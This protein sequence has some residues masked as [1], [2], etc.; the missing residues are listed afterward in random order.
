MIDARCAP[1]DRVAAIV[2]A[3]RPAPDALRRLISALASQV[4]AIFV[5]DNTP[6][7]ERGARV[8]LDAFSE[9]P[10]T[11]LLETGENLGIAAALNIGIRLAMERGFDYLL[12]SDQDSEPAPDMVVH[13]LDVAGQL[14]KQGVRLGAIGPAYLDRVT[15]STFGFQVHPEGSLFYRTLPGDQADPWVEVVTSITSGSLVPCSAITDIGLMREDYFI[16]YVDTEWC[17][18]ARHHGYRLFGT[19]RARMEHHLGDSAFP[20]WYLRWRSF[21]GY[22]PVRL[23]YRFRNFMVLFRCDYVPWHWKVRAGWY[24]L[25]NLYAYAVFAP[26]RMRNLRYIGL[27]LWDGLHGRMGVYRPR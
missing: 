3:F 18:R 20:V 25:G 22:S 19:S 5:I 24:W 9:S 8:A 7:G 6:V 23:Y 16:D 11:T 26:R 10:V 1:E 2:V 15:G 12:L 4:E 21:T 13:L 17:H 27:G 14:V